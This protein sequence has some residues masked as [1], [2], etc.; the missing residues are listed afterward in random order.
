[1]KLGKSVNTAQKKG[2]RGKE[3][4]KHANLYTGTISLLGQALSSDPEGTRNIDVLSP[5]LC[6]ANQINS[7]L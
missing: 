2:G 5:V 4:G 6:P 1:M 3:E 7:Q